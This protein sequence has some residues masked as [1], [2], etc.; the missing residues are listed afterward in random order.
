MKLMK[1]VAFWHRGWLS[2]F[3][4]WTGRGAF[5]SG[6]PPYVT[7]GGRVIG[8]SRVMVEGCRS[9]IVDLTLRQLGETPPDSSWSGLICLYS[10]ALFVSHSSP[11]IQTLPLPDILTHPYDILA[12]N[13]T[14]TSID[15]SDCCSPNTKYVTVW[16]QQKPHIFSVCST[17]VRKCCWSL[18]FY[19]EHP[20]HEDTWVDDALFGWTRGTGESSLLL[21]TTAKGSSKCITR[22]T[23]PTALHPIQN[24]TRELYK[25]LG[26]DPALIR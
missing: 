24:V 3:N 21:R 26:H 5:S 11:F 13:K 16:R 18:H 19:Y 8:W 25:R 10:L 4:L 7:R 15:T 17:N 2:P 20:D 6:R 23:G 14:P 12:Y 9:W 22:R 1:K